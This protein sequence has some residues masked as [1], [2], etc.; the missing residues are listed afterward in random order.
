MIWKKKINTGILN[1]ISKNTMVQHLGIKFVEIGDDYIIATMPVD[2]RTIQPA[3]LLHGGASV[4]LAET[5]GSVASYAFVE[6]EDY[7]VVGIEINA[8]HLKAKRKGSGLVTGKVTPVKTGRRIHVWQ[9]VIT[10]ENQE[11]VCVS[12]LTTMVIEPLRK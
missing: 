1:N 2:H 6:E 3:G 7:D 4:T 11:K 10:D 8:N 5:L 9:I 12:R